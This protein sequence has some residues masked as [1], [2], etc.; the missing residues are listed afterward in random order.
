MKVLAIE[1]SCDDTSLA[2]VESE[3]GGIFC[4]AMVAA[5]QLD[6]HRDYG[7]VV[8]EL[9]SRSHLKD[10]VPLLSHLSTQAWYDTLDMMLSD[11]D[12]IA[13]TTHP[14][15]PGSLIMG[16]TCA[17][18][19]SEWYDIPYQW[20]NHLHGHALSFL[21][22]RQNFYVDKCLILSISGGH[23]DLSLLSLSHTWYDIQQIWKTRDDAIG[24]V[25]DKV[26]RMLWWPYP[27]G[28]RI[29]D[30]A[31]LYDPDTIIDYGYR[32]KKI[33]VDGYDYSFSGMKSQ[34]YNFITDYTKKYD[35]DVLSQDF[36]RYIAYY[37]QE[38]V[39]D[40]VLHQL[41][42]VYDDIQFDHIAIVGWVSANLRLRE[43]IDA[44]W[45]SRQ[46]WWLSRPSVYFPLN[47][48][49]CTDNAAMIGVVGINGR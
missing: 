20:I 38:A 39:L 29:G 18:F 13:V 8:P 35:T 44:R 4:R 45:L 41:Y 43:K 22:D 33:V 3:S 40:S 49:Y 19:L 2:I 26:S 34:V 36:I 9:A 23:S 11:M 21:L 6:I 48:A 32:I 31:T 37:F 12:R 7:G 17:Y 42:K 46:L 15:L 47:F 14:W 10:I 25:F 16:R 28:K 1:T 24:E 5:S 30:Q 27:W